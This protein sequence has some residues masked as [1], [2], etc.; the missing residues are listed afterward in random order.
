VCG[1]VN[2]K[3]KRTC[4][5]SYK[6]DGKPDVPKNK[7]DYETAKEIAENVLDGEKDTTA[8][9][10]FFHNNTVRPAWAKPS[11]LTAVIGNHKFYRG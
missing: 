6:C 3:H 2:Q 8:G 1:V 11:R 10:L 9:A 4:Q 5:F 7:E